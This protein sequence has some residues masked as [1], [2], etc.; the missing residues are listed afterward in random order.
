MAAIHQVLTATSSTLDLEEVLEALLDNLR[1]IAG[2]DRASVMLLDPRTDQLTSTAARDTAGPLPVG[3]RLARGEGA[4]GRVVAEAK[5]FIVPDLRNFPEFAPPHGPAAA[6]AHPVPRALSYAGFP[7][8]SRGRVLG[9]V[10]LIGTAPRDYALDETTFIE[11]ICRAAAVSIDNA[12]AHQ[13]LRRHAER[14]TGEFAVHRTYAENVLRSITDGV[15][16][17]DRHRRVASWNRGAEGILGHR[18]AQVLGKSCDEIFCARRAG[19]E[20]LCHT[21]DCIFDEIARTRQPCPRREVAGRRHDGQAVTLSLSATPLFDE[22][23][24]FQGI[25]KIFHDLSY[26][27]ALRDGLVQMLVH[28]LRSPLS[29]ILSYLEMIAEAAKEKLA[30][31]SHRD[32]ESAQHAAHGMARM[33]NGILDVSKMEARMMKLELGACDL[34]EVIGQSL[35]DFASLVGARELD[36]EHPTPPVAVR[37]DRGIVARIVQN[38]VA[39]ALRLTPAGGRIQIGVVVEAQNVKVFVT[40]TG[41]GIPPAFR[42]RIFDTFA[43]VGPPAASRLP[44]SGLG[45]AFC[46]LAVEAHGGCI[47]VESEEGNGSTFWFTLPCAPGSAPTNRT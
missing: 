47:G 37:A 7:L 36:F 1:L 27:R 46:K 6:P 34:V 17:I 18:A 31:E 19:G 26:E 40:D 12:L 3:L 16:T 20:T 29:A 44:T 2:A 45:L 41:P 11:T 5:P 9:V 10:S 43:Q 8:V 25:V 4:G 38:L 22:R 24:E 39:N 15:A 30:V 14:V 21:G 32:I 13:E 23:G 35:D 28:D 42:H 33:I